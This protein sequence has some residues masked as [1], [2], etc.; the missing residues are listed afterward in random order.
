MSQALA[1]RDA[2]WDNRACAGV[3]TRHGH[4]ADHFKSEVIVPARRPIIPR[5]L[6][7]RALIDSLDLGEQLPYLLL[8]ED[9]FPGRLG[10]RR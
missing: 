4:A 9:L 1:Q 7:Y 2:V 8:A 5:D 3:W 6:R 10:R